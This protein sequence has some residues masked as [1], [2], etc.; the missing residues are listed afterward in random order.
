MVRRAHGIV[1]SQIPADADGQPTSTPV[2]TQ[3]THKSI[4]RDDGTGGL[5]VGAA[6]NGS[7]P[8]HLMRVGYAP[9][10]SRHSRAESGGHRG[11]ATRAGPEG[12]A[13]GVT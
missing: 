5:A 9:D 11:E 1:S 3:I 4:L 7:L 13:H 10:F 2:A 8:E 12:P 6:N